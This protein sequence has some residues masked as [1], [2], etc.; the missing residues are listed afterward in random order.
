MNFDEVEDAAYEPFERVY[1]EVED[2]E[3][4]AVINLTDKKQVA[5]LWL[6]PEAIIIGGVIIGLT[7]MQN[8]R[9]K[10]NVKEDKVN[11]A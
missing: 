4:K 5:W 8:K 9:K 7:V 2:E 6:I 11:E 10:D 1:A 3:D